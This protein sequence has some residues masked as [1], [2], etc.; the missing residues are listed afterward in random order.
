M[1]G[2]LVEYQVLPLGTC[3]PSVSDLVA[4]AVNVIR[5]KG[6]QFKVTPMATV[7]KV[8]DLKEAGELAQEI[9]EEMKKKGVKRI[10]MVMRADVR[11]DKELDMDKKIES[12]LEKLETK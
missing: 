5:K 2:I 11:F 12:V 4:A 1:G 3:S 8:N 10:V 9:V 6:L 7:V